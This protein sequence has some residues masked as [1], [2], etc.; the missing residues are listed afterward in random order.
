MNKCELLYDHYKDTF[1]IIENRI[2]SRNRHFVILFV[3]VVLQFL[4]AVSPLSIGT[5]LSAI[6]RENYKIDISE[7]MVTIQCF[8]WILLLYFTT[9]YYQTVIHIEKQY[10]YIETLEATLS[11]EIGIPFEREGNYYLQN[12]PKISDMIDFLYKWVFPI[13]YCSV[14][15]I[16]I[17]NEIMYEGLGFAMLFDIVI[18]LCCFV[19]TV[20]YLVFLNSKGLKQK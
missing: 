1:A 18:F 13:M 9:R 5:L 10:K 19:L 3:I 11:A 6:V 16:K 2:V 7:Q 14:I 12:Y 20:L 17:I 15:L 8:L 4:F